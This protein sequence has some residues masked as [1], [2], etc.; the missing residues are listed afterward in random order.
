M[1]YST[2][3]VTGAAGF[4]GHAVLLELQRVCPEAAIYALV[5]PGDPLAGTLPPGVHPVEGDVTDPHTL[6]PFFA[7]AG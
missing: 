3:L 6:G 1:T 5:L 7:H 4:L 2:Y